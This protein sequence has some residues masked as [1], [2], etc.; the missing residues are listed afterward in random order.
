MKTY[1]KPY[2]TEIRLSANDVM[3]QS[4]NVGSSSDDENSAFDLRIDVTKQGW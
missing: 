4:W 1:V 2:A 3:N